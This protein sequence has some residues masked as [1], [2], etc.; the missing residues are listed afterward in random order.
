[1]AIA[2]GGT[3]QTSKSAAFNALS[4]VT[5]LGDLIY[6][7][8]ANSATRLAGNATATPMFLKQTGTGSASAAPVWST[9]SSSDIPW[10]TPG[11]IGSTT[12]SSA[13]FTT[14]STSGALTA[15]STMAQTLTSDETAF[16]IIAN[17]VTTSDV[18]TMTA[19]GLTTGS[20]LNLATSSSI[21]GNGLNVSITGV[22]SGSAVNRI[23]VKSVVSTTGSN[24]TNTAAYFSATGA[25]NSY[26]L[27][28]NLG[29]VG[30]GTSAPT[31]LFEVNGVARM[32]TFSAAS[33]ST[34][35]KDIDFSTGNS[36]TSSV[37]CSAHNIDFHNMRDGGSYV[38][39]ITNTGTATC[40]FNTS[41]LDVD[42]ATV[43]YRFKPANGNRTASSHTV[44]RLL[45]VGNVVYVSWES[46]Y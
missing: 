34:N 43:T 3:G 20:V 46:G 17:S 24:H 44:Y 15:S 33:A 26:A 28:T 19:N 4:P 13:A 22:N 42:A 41:L 32:T 21:G 23:G 8:G 31:S 5:T 16:S 12:P 38:L 37:D 11:T 25:T 27:I 30:I 45:R 10:A 36:I 2:N 18:T 9:L 29:N 40:S 6:G 35:S 39:V 1:M 14:L 7:N